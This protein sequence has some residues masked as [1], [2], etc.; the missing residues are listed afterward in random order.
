MPSVSHWELNSFFINNTY[1]AEL[2]LVIHEDIKLH[3]QKI[4]SLK[5]NE[6]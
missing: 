6:F 4:I 2:Q 5:K 3:P 1:Q